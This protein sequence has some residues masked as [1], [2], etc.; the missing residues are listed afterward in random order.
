MIAPTTAEP[1]QISARSPI[2]VLQKGNP[3]HTPPARRRKQKPSGVTGHSE[4]L[5]LKSTRSVFWAG[6]IRERRNVAS[7][8][9]RELLSS[10]R[11]APGRLVATNRQFSIAPPRS[12][13]RSLRL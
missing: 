5:T 2:D 3:D 10:L 12:G 8:V 9:H 4:F 6:Q 13:I 7:L 11:H 1:I